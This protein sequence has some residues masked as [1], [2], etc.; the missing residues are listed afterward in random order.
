M[1]RL[2]LHN[3]VVLLLVSVFLLTEFA[4]AEIY[5]WVD[6]QGNL[7]FGDK[8]KDPTEAVDAEKVNLK[9]SYQP[10]VRT[11]Q[12]QAEYDEQQ[13]RQR[14]RDEMRQRDDQQAQQEEAAKRSQ[15]KAALCKAYDESIDELETVKVEDGVRHL[16]Y[17]TDED[18][19][20]VSSDRQREIIADLKSKKAKAGCP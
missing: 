2:A 5:K 17:A 1:R 9:E 13:R 19:K 18:G 6:A 4:T 10:A 3:Q 8:P 15:Q 16:V 12:E 7:H 20:P 11:P 14:L